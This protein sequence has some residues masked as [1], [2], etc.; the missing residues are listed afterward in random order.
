MLRYTQLILWRI[1]AVIA[2]LLGLIGLALPIVPTVPFLILAAWAAGKGSPRLERWLL[3]HPRFGQ[4]IRA[5]RERRAVPRRAKV[6][7]VLMMSVSAI[8]L[9]FTST[10]LWFRI[11]VPLTMA[12][13]AIWLCTRPED[14]P[15]N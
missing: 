3:N 8:S 11:A 2:L 7:A 4:H 5:W 14:P 12:S 15:P 9:Q 10:Q 1:A 6:F 13:I